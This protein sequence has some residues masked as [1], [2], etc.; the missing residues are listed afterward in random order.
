MKKWVAFLIATVLLVTG[1]CG[2]CTGASAAQAGSNEAVLVDNPEDRTTAEY[3]QYLEDCENG[4]TAKYGGVIPRAVTPSYADDDDNVETAAPSYDPRGEG[5]L[6]QLI[7]RE[8]HS[9]Y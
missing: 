2:V 6:T 8:L 4:D 1:T 7:S 3:L 5:W 9:Y